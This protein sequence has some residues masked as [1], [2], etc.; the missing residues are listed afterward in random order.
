[1]LP[2][3]LSGFMASKVPFMTYHELKSVEVILHLNCDKYRFKYFNC[4]LISFSN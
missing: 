1:M 3:I 2:F 4:D